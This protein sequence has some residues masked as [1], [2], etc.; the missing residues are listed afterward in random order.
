MPLVNATSDYDHRE[1]ITYILR[2]NQAIGVLK[3]ERILLC[4]FQIRANGLTVED[5]SRKFESEGRSIRSSMVYHK[6]GL[7]FSL[8]LSGMIS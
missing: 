1:G 2:V 5:F 7:G 6:S 8:A 4:P 3:E